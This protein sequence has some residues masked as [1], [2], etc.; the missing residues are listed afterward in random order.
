ME[1][2]TVY[3]ET[4]NYRCIEYRQVLSDD[5]YMKLCGLEQCFSGKSFGP[6]YRDGYHLHAVLSGKGTLKIDGKEYNVHAGQL[7]VTVPDH[8][9]WYQADLEDPWYY[10]WITFDGNKAKTYLECAGFVDDVYVLDCTIDESQF[11]AVLKQ[12]L[13]RPHLNLTS[14]LYRMGLVYQFLS[15]AVESYDK[16]NQ[17]KNKNNDLT[18]DDY[19]DYAIKYIQGNY[20]NAKINNVA[21][22]IGVNRTY[23]ATVFKKRMC[24]SPQEYLMQVRM[25]KG[26]ELLITTDFPINVIAPNVGYENPLTF[27]K[28][29]KRKYGLSPE[30]YRKKN[31]E[32]E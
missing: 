7:F 13:E 9:T 27:S 24:M 12:M 8:E 31:R 16:N 14:D 1:N 18:P 32:C 5:L 23:L 17:G 21:K 25:N 2:E 15:L 6:T 10:C 19:V 22:Y 29:F 3:F 26:A 28:M 20:T 4:Q 30:N 11:L